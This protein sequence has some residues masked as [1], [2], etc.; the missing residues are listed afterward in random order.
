MRHV[1][2]PYGVGVGVGV[3]VVW[4]ETETRFHRRRDP[5]HGGF[6]RSGARPG[7][8]RV[9]SVRLALTA[10]RPSAILA[11]AAPTRFSVDQVHQACG[12]P[13]DRRARRVSTR[14]IRGAADHAIAVPGEYRPGPLGVRPTTRSRCQASIDQVHQACGRPRDRRATRGSRPVLMV[15]IAYGTSGRERA[16]LLDRGEAV[17]K[18]IRGAGG[19]S[20]RRTSVSRRRSP[21]R[22]RHC[23]FSRPHAGPTPWRSARGAGWDRG[24]RD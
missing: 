7:S 6:A 1:V 23:T 19:T 16:D 3:G 18:D 14:S 17:A 2:R 8:N 13:R 20:R 22:R 9:L 11:R 4:H 5:R 24:P 15:P 10:I 12:R 21:S